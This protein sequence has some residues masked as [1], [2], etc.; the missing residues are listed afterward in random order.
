V[1]DKVGK[2]VYSKR[3]AIHEIIKKMEQNP[4]ENKCSNQA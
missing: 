1:K 4:D 3:K 2:S